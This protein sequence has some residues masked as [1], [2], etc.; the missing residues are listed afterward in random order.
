MLDITA[1]LIGVFDD[2]HHLFKQALRISRAGSLLVATTDGVTEA[3]NA[4]GQLFGLERFVALVS[5]CRDLPE[6]AIVDR[7]LHEDRNVLSRPPP[8]RYRDHRR[9]RFRV[10]LGAYRPRL[11]EN[12]YSTKLRASRLVAKTKIIS[13]AAAAY[14]SA[15]ASGNGW[16]M[17]VQTTYVR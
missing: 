11:R 7:I 2:Q 16:L 12:L 17:Y 15:C 3:R 6:A 13:S 9:P 8:R 14:A 5:E 10:F 1:P 4:D